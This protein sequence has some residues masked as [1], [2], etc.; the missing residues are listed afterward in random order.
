M[1]S[2]ARRG[3]PSG[4]AEASPRMKLAIGLYE[5]GAVPTK[6]RAADVVG[7]SRHTF[8]FRYRNGFRH[9]STEE[10]AARV[11]ASVE[12][13]IENMSDYLD[14]ASTAAIRTLKEIMQDAGKSEIVRLKAAIDLADRGPRTSKITKIQ[15]TQFSMQGTDITELSAALVAARN[16]RLDHKEGIE[17]DFVKVIEAAEPIPMITDGFRRPAQSGS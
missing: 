10:V 9:K 15:S 4:S 3:R 1:R 6:A 2:F 7:L 13:K 8:Y 5:T 16:A 11:K 14:E 17:G 12:E